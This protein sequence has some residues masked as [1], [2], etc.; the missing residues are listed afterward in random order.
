MDGE[1]D[2]PNHWAILLLIGNPYGIQTDART[3]HAV[4]EPVW[5]S[6]FGEGRFCTRIRRDLAGAVL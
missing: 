4:L 1:D 6:A 3:W 2:I 5:V